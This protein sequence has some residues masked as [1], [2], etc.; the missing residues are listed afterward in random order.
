MFAPSRMGNRRSEAPMLKGTDIRRGLAGLMLLAIPLGLLGFLMLMRGEFRDVR[1]LRALVDKSVEARAELAELLVEHLNVETGQRG[2][3]L[4][5]K[6]EFLTPYQE[7]KA[8]IRSE[9]HTSEPP[10]TRPS[11]MPSS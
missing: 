10:V 4:T 3:V 2:Y 7:G 1:E 8:G 5:G 6:R 11:R 9:E